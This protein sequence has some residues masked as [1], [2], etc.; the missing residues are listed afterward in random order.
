MKKQTLFSVAAAILMG[1][2]TLFAVLALAYHATGWYERQPAGI[3]EMTGMIL[4]GGNLVV[5]LVVLLRQL[6]LRRKQQRNN[7]MRRDGDMYQHQ[8]S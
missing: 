4:K 7:K 3:K 8:H 1:L 5:L 6:W 2:L